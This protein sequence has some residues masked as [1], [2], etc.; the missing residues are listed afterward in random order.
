MLLNGISKQGFDG[1]VNIA[2]EEVGYQVLGSDIPARAE[3]AFYQH[4]ILIA[5]ELLTASRG[6]FGE[7]SFILSHMSQ[8]S[9]RNYELDTARAYHRA[10]M[11]AVISGT[12]PSGT[13]PLSLPGSEALFLYHEPF[14]RHSVYYDTQQETSVAAI[15]AGGRRTKNSQAARHQRW[16]YM[17]DTLQR[18]RLAH[19]GFGLY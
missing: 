5:R 18:D 15:P 4:D 8:F 12:I 9:T 1:S 2:D 17:L 3:L 10:Q 11:A 14:L 16:V 19:T 6:M 7:S 13:F